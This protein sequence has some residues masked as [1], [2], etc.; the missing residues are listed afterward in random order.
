M[1]NKDPSL[2]DMAAFYTGTSYL[3]FT[4]LHRLL[5]LIKIKRI[6]AYQDNPFY[7]LRIIRLAR[8]QQSPLSGSGAEGV[9]NIIFLCDIYC[10]MLHTAF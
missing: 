9:W 4:G 8:E 3:A 1:G 6:A 7:P 10:F 5:I 2:A